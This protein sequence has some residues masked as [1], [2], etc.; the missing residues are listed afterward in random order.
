MTAE[1]E[2]RVRWLPLDVLRFDPANP[3]LE[4]QD[5][6]ASQEDLAMLLDQLYDA[7]EVAASIAGRGYFPSE[8]LIGIAG[9]QP[10][11]ITIVEGNRRLAA[12]K[13]LAS[14]EFRRRM[15][16]P[17]EW[18]RL[19]ASAEER[20]NIPRRVPVLVEPNRDAVIAAIGYRHISGIKAWEP[21]QQAR[22]V[23]ERVDNDGLSLKEVAELIGTSV[24]EV[25][26]KYR[27][28][29]IVRAA[30]KA[31]IDS[32]LVQESFGVWDAALGRVALRQFIGAVDP[33]QVR[34]GEPVVAEDR[35]DNLRELIGWLFGPTKLIRE[36]RD[37]AALGDVV[38][39]PT[40]L[41]AIRGGATL[42]EAVDAMRVPKSDNERIRQTLTT[43]NVSLA[44]ALQLIDGVADLERE[45]VLEEPAVRRL[46]A[47]VIASSES[48]RELT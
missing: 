22:Y 34:P 42:H 43:A 8:V 25:R 14:P 4:D 16:E 37:L 32:A 38:G 17:A 20:G 24:T 29:G 23:A 44:I 11:T 6:G 40:G 30:E 46:V 13:A 47:E 18:E 1:A 36:S 33:G 10:D 3:R 39:N 19:A 35:T 5:R 45:A 48:L 21:Y 27:N 9:D 12:A 31:G 28:Y 2:D 41:A 26:N 7:R 15:S